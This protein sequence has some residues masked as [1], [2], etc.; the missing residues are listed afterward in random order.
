MMQEH[1]QLSK[2]ASVE[3][4]RQLDSAS[5]NFEKH[6]DVVAQTLMFDS[7]KHTL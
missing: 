5:T 7:M 4:K 2:R 6:L 3:A 1:R